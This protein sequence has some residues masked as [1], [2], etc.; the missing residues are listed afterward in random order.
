VT[1]LDL[2]QEVEYRV[3]FGQEPGRLPPGGIKHRQFKEWRAR[4]FRSRTIDDFTCVSPTDSASPTTRALRTLGTQRPPQRTPSIPSS[5]PMQPLAHQ[6]S[7][8]LVYTSSLP[9]AATNIHVGLRRMGAGANEGLVELGNAMFNRGFG[10]TRQEDS[11][12]NREGDCEAESRT[13]N[14]M[15]SHFVASHTSNSSTEYTSTMSRYWL[16]SGFVFK[17]EQ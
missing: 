2:R 12:I 8:P 14:P 15:D 1:Y 11:G 16:S 4:H 3:R 13:T 6:G 17:I 10:A 5:P 9:Q 7:N